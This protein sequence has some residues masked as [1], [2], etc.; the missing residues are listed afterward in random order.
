MRF[1]ELARLEEVRRREP[2]APLVRVVAL[3]GFGGADRGDDLAVLSADGPVGAVV[4]AGLA[5][6]LGSD[7]T[8][9]RARLAID[10][11]D[12]EGHGLACG[13]W[14]DV[15]VHPVGWI[16]DVVDFVERRQPFVVRTP[17]VE[18]VPA[19]PC[20][21]VA[22]PTARP[23]VRVGDELHL[24]GFAPTPRLVVAGEGPLVEELLGLARWLGAEA[25]ASDAIA[26]LG[27]LDGVVVLTHDHDRATPILARAI[28]VGAGYVAALGSRETQAERRRR[29]ALA[30]ANPNR[31]FGPAGL[32][33]GA[34]SVRETALAI[35]AEW[36]GVTHG[37]SRGSLRD[38]TG[39][40]NG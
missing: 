5:E 10:D 29:L 32:D 27:P 24:H 7:P 16:G 14:V 22:D 33:L 13:G 26:S 40:I 12:A 1:E 30:G 21:L 3:H 34:R 8:P 25:E 11:R 4:M 38:G 20:E 15:M 9:R 28:E 18:G 23:G 39:P 17:L 6:Q 31:L 35:V 37:R 2:E 19:E 36:V